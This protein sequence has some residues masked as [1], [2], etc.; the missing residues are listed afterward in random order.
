MRRSATTTA[1]A[2]LIR[3]VP[4]PAERALWQLLRGRGVGGMKFR[5]MEPVA[6]HIAPFACREARLILDLLPGPLAT[7]DDMTRAADFRAVGWHVLCL[8]EAEVLAA[9]ETALARLIR[10]GQA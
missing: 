4:S 9:P 7:A 1:E 8:I 6:G 5:R 2:R 10:G 3:Q